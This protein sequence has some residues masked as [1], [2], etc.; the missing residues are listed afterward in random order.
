[1]PDG[2]HAM[3]IQARRLSRTLRLVVVGFFLR[4]QLTALQKMHRLIE[5][6]GIAG[7]LHITAGCIR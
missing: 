5:Y 2:T 1:M 7:R 6:A 3:F 4:I